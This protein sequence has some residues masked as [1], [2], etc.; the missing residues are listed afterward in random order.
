MPYINN[1]LDNTRVAIKLDTPSS[2]PF[3]P[4][5]FPGGVTCTATLELAS[6]WSILLLFGTSEY[7]MLSLR[8]ARVVLLVTSMDSGF[9]VAN[10]RSCAPLLGSEEPSATNFV[11]TSPRTSFFIVISTIWPRPP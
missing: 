8:I 3:D 6:C 2:V 11:S 10:L 5:N 4:E 9:L 1:D 7:N